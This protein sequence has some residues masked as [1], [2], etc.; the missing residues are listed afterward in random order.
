MLS[1]VLYVG[2][3]IIYT[4]FS[5]FVLTNGANK[6]AY[7]AYYYSMFCNNFQSKESYSKLLLPRY[8]CSSIF[9][10]GT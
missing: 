8:V 2:I 3:C 10:V 4:Y 9:D 1:K 6:Y 7:Y 5:F